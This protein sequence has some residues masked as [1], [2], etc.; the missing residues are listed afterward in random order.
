MAMRVSQHL[1]KALE[2]SIDK[3]YFNY[4]EYEEL[5][6]GRE[7]ALYTL[8]EGYALGLY[9]IRGEEEF[10]IRAEGLELLEAWT[11]A[12]KPQVD[13]WID[14]RIYTMLYTIHYSGTTPD[15]WKPI[16]GDRGL[17]GGDGLTPAGEK[18]YQLAPRLDR[19][20]VIT[21][22]MAR[23]LAK[24]PDGPAPG[25][26]YGRYLP[27]YEA[28]G[29]VVGTV[30][31]NPY[32]SL[33]LPGRLLAR[34]MRRL[35]LDA[36]LPSILNP[37]V[38]KALQSLEE[39]GELTP[40]EKT[41]LGTLGYLKPTGTLDYPGKLV[42]EAYK[43]LRKT[44][45]RPPMALASQEEK[46]VKAVRD[47][48]REAQEK[49]NLVP[50]K[51]LIAKKYRELTGEDPGASLGLDLMH[52]ES[53]GLIEEYSID[54]KPAYRLTRQGERLAEAPG[55]GNGS[56]APAVKAITYPYALLSPH[57]SWVESAREA[58]LVGAGGPT[59][60][61]EELARLSNTPRIPLLTRPEARALQ[62]IPDEKSVRR[63]TLS[64]LLE[65]MGTDPERSLE[66]LEAR[67][68]I[69]TLPDNTV[70]L[71]G[72]G[73]LVK[74]ALLGVPDGIATPIYPALIRVLAAINQLGTEDLARIVNYTGLT[75]GTVKDALVIARTA[76]YLGKK[77]G[78][79]SAGQALLEAVRQLAM[80]EATL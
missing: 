44:R 70:R 14:S 47:A 61:G 66:R 45:L 63:Q 23:A 2:A 3:G 57:L 77:G 42:L 80:E 9:R 16:L 38:L 53:M 37:A 54:E 60:K 41:L 1:L 4:K 21:K 12:G 55:L 35:N 7:E 25:K 72:P 26:D 39:G 75:L 43:S 6:G 31:L 52:L 32:Y 10:E 29:L 64:S 36:P 71:T 65:S 34:A 68:L 78:L 18:V 59:R 8:L 67:G 20:L 79:T 51:D 30:P 74:L 27:V 48:V 69:E 22:S 5:L 28:M 33:T 49:P 11:T 50:D 46:L 17:I 19:G 15:E 13:P 62:S 24:A 58:G 73:R 40:E 76:K 56:P